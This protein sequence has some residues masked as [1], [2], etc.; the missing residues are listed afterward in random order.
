MN[1]NASNQDY[2]EIQGKKFVKHIFEKFKLIFTVHQRHNGRLV[3]RVK[4][5]I[6]II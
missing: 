3:N 1:K 2:L 4:I 5:C 6:Y